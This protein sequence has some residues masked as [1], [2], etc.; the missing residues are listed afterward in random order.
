MNRIS[1]I[2]RAGVL[3]RITRIVIHF[4]AG[5]VLSRRVIDV[6]LIITTYPFESMVQVEPVADLV[7]CGQAQILTLLG[8]TRHGRCTNHDSVQCKVPRTLRVQIWNGA[9]ASDIRRVVK[10]L[11]NQVDVQGAVVALSESFLIGVRVIVVSREVG[12]VRVNRTG[13]VVEVER[14]TVRCICLVDHRKLVV[15]LFLSDI[16]IFLTFGSC[17]IVEV[18]VDFESPLGHKP[19]MRAL[20]L[21]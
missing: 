1:S 15:D 11:V 20:I 19:Q 5:G 10:Y 7:D 12:P 13:D 9:V 8:A 16:S 21:Q 18:R 17:H 14:N 6:I 2:P 3:F 4:T